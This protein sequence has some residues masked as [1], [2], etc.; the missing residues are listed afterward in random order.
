[1]Y[2]RTATLKKIHSAFSASRVSPYVRLAALFGFA[3]GLN[4]QAMAV[5]ADVLN[6]VEL[7]NQSQFNELAESLGAATHYK[8]IAPP[9]TLGIIGFD[10]GVEVS[11]TDISG[12]L[13]DLASDGSFAGSELVIPRLHVHKGLPFGIDLG[14]SMGAVQD[15]DG[16]VFGA[17]VRFAIVEGGAVTPAL[18]LRVSHSQMHGLDD[19]DFNSTGIELAV[20]KG[21]LF[22]T[23]YA[24]VGFL[25]SSAQPNDIA[26]LASKSVDQQK[27]VVGVTINFGFALTLEVDRTDDYRTYSAKAGIRF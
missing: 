11:S 6:S 13:F 26:S 27:L 18:G 20:S 15:S 4:L 24:G 1:M 7:L 12:D 16:R 17:E 3:I 25:R 21:F 8:S 5:R 23:P 22:V 14:A 9:E 19:L 2:K 10:I